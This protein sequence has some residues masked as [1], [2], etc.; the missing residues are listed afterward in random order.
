MYG[1]GGE[2]SRMAMEIRRND[3]ATEKRK[4]EHS[5]SI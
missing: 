1:E 2:G 3:D 5:V 4:K